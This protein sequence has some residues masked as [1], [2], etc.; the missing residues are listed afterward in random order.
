MLNEKLSIIYEPKPY[1]KDLRML[2]SLCIYY[3]DIKLFHHTE[4]SDDYS[5]WLEKHSKEFNDFLLGPYDILSYEGILDIYTPERVSQLFPETN[6]LE[7]SINGIDNNDDGIVFDIDNSQVINK[8]TKSI[9][10]SLN[11]RIIGKKPK[12]S[13]LIRAINIYS[14]AEIYNIPI[15]TNKDYSIGDNL[16]AEQTVRMISDKLAIMTINKFALPELCAQN[17]EDIIVAREK[18]KDELI[19]FRTG[20]LDLTYHLCKN[21]NNNVRDLQYECSLLVETKIKASIMNL[22]N[23]INKNKSKRIRNLIFN[24]SKLILTGSNIFLAGA[25]LK[26]IISNGT[27]LLDI[28]KDLVNSNIPEERIASFTYNTKRI[29][30]KQ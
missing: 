18:L 1:I 7:L 13:D 4:I 15:M 29:L 26:D 16:T 3:D 12:V 28:S 20:I 17:I 14:V 2:T 6:D 23:A 5:E 27:S 25:T 11:P 9:F 30:S 10:T 21:I 24:T 19:E 8:L 22:E